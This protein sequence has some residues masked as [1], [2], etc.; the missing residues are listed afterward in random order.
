MTLGDGASLKINEHIDTVIG[1][2]GGGHI[3]LEEG[4]SL[5]IN[6]HIDTLTAGPAG[7]VVVGKDAA[8]KIDVHADTATTS[9]EALVVPATNRSPAQRAPT[10]ALCACGWIARRGKST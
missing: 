2:G 7:D 1:S 3:T 10:A 6:E 5:T 8:L 9:P 4:A